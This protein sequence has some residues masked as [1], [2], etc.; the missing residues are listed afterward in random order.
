[1]LA[2]LAYGVKGGKWYSLMDKAYRQETLIKAFE[3]FFQQST[4]YESI[5]EK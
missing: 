3:R 1:M 5:M 2:A 4:I